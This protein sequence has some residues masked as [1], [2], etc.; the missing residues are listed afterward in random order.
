MSNTLYFLSA[1]AKLMSIHVF[2]NL[3]FTKGTDRSL[4]SCEI[5]YFIYFVFNHRINVLPLK[6]KKMCYRIKKGTMSATN[7]SNGNIIGMF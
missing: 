1:S 6:V 4:C 3:M 7:A 5:K 2:A